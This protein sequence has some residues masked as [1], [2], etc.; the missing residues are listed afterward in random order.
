MPNSPTNWQFCKFCVAKGPAPEC[1]L[2][3]KVNGRPMTGE[4][5]EALLEAYLT[6]PD[7]WWKDVPFADGTTPRQR[8]GELP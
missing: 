1:F 6:A 2:C 8:Q 3:E 7:D 4:E 5:Q